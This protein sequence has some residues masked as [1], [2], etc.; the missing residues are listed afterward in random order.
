MLSLNWCLFTDPATAAELA[1]REEVDSRSVFVGNVRNSFSWFI[2][3][4]NYVI[5]V[6][7]TLIFF[8]LKGL[9]HKSHTWFSPCLSYLLICHPS[10]QSFNPCTVILVSSFFI[11]SFIV[12][13][14]YNR[15]QVIISHL[16]DIEC[17]IC[18][19]WSLFVSLI[20]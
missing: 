4:N 20:S 19:C 5:Y 14:L 6:T 10:K 11:S 15:S 3:L 13:P 18:H 8:N 17:D 2:S 12:L 7:I 9:T 16:L 1:N